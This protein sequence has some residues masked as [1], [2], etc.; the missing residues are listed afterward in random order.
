MIGV[1]TAL[2]AGLIIST[3]ALWRRP[4]PNHSFIFH[5]NKLAEEQAATETLLSRTHKQ[6]HGPH[7]Q[8]WHVNA[9]VR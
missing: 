5:L 7:G 2:V 8:D 3:A 6:R 1:A 4:A 9:K